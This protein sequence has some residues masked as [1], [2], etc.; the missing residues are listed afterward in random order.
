MINNKIDVLGIGNAIVDVLAR[1]D[2]KFLVRHGLQKGSMVLI[3]AENATHLYSEMGPAIEASGGSAANTIAGIA[4]LG[5]KTGFIGRVA[6]DQ[7]GEVFSHDIRS[8]G[9]EYSTQLGRDGTPTA[10]SFILVTP[11][12]ERTM[13]TFLGASQGLSLEDL[14][15]DL[16][17]RAKITYLEG[18][19][20]DPKEAKKAFLKAMEISKG[21]GN[22]VALTLSDGFCVV[23]YREEFKE[24]VDNKVDILFANEEEIKSLYEVEDFEEA[25]SFVKGKAELIVLTRGEKGAII[26][27]GLERFDVPAEPTDVVDT[28]GAGDLY[29][30]G[31]LYGYCQGYEMKKCGKIAA[32]CAAEVISHF[33][34]RPKEGLKRLVSSKVY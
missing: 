10:R 8:L 18:Y 27:K 2:D 30:A 21:A 29:A 13:N 6:N 23:R 9:V 16:I 17:K 7:L 31:F 19:L 32:I 4:S 14:N 24:L 5:G 25:V 20:W 12:G 34:A 11:D 28:T 22:K 3:D 26:L 15:E 33:G 1:T